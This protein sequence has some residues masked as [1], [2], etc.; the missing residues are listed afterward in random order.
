[1]KKKGI[2]LIGSLAIMVVAMVFIA[3]TVVS[4]SSVTPEASDAATV[5]KSP[6]V[7]LPENVSYQIRNLEFDKS[8]S[9]YPGVWGINDK[10]YTIGSAFG[11]VNDLQV[12]KSYVWDKNG[13]SLSLTPEVSDDTYLVDINNDNVVLMQNYPS[14]A[15][16]RGYV[17][18][19]NTKKLTELVYKPAVVSKSTTTKNVA[20]L[21]TLKRKSLTTPNSLKLPGLKAPY[22]LP[23][24]ICDID[25]Y[26]FS[27]PSD[28][29]DNNDV[30][31]ET[32]KGLVLWTNTGKPNQKYYY[33]NDLLNSTFKITGY[34]VV[35]PRLTN[36]TANS[37][38]IVNELHSITTDEAEYILYDFDVAKGT[39]SNLVRVTSTTPI[40]YGTISRITDSKQFAFYCGRILPNVSKPL[41][42]QQTLDTCYL[43][44]NDNY[45][46]VYSL[47]SELE[48]ISLRGITFLQGSMSKD[49]T[50]MG[51]ITSE[52]STSL[53][54]E[55]YF[56]YNPTKKEYLIMDN[57]VK[58]G[59]I[60]NMP[61]TGFLFPT[62]VN[63]A[64][65]VSINYMKNIDDST[66][67]GLGVLVPYNKAGNTKT[68][69]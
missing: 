1:M 8:T 18:D 67:G 7:P 45:K 35:G 5:K 2:L 36:R 37:I 39:L 42:Q 51:R 43:S 65:D 17:Y 41:D 57:L 48:K 69:K 26:E 9:L 6:S 23:Q 68:T 64:G 11:F 24:D 66:T 55:D 32:E 61:T 56:V 63:V 49:G 58:Q 15:V 59:K 54:N 25:C 3:V 14:S 44:K 20:S 19:V 46:T 34:R 4:R 31:G 40:W 29:N 12:N 30:V 47:T 52:K 62:G 53:Y 27:Y 38:T 22:A 13:K 28:I 60:L 50:F 21:N 16:N 10:G 33:L